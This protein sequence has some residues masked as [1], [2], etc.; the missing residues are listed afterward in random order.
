MARLNFTHTLSFNPAVYSVVNFK[1]MFIEF[2]VI[3]Y[4]HDKYIYDDDVRCPLSFIHSLMDAGKL[5]LNVSQFS[6]TGSSLSNVL[7]CFKLSQVLYILL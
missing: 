4:V 5:S 2:Y 6:S 3:I 1:I 7:V